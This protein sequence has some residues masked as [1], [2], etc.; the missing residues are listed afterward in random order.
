MAVTVNLGDIID[1][2][3]FNSDVNQS[4]INK[5]T[6]KVVT[7]SDEVFSYVDDEEIMD[8]L[9]DWQKE[10]VETTKEILYTEDYISLPDKFDVDEYRLMERFCLSVSD[11]GLREKIYYS[12]KGRGAFRTF[13]NNIHR[14]GLADEWYRYRDGYY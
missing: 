3:E 4:Y 5:N 13:K 9:P 12:I 11:E 14:F 8:E 2:I 1:G 6:G 7:I 10:E